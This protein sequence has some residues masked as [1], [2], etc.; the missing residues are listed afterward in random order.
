MEILAANGLGEFDE[1]FLVA[2]V[3]LVGLTTAQAADIA[4]RPVYTKAPVAVLYTWAGFYVGAN[5][6]GAVGNFHPNTS[7]VVDPVN[8]LTAANAAIVNQQ[9]ALFGIKPTGFV[10]GIQA[11]YN[12]QS[13][14][15]LSGLEADVQSFHLRGSSSIASNLVGPIP[16]LLTASAS[17]DWLAT[18]RGRLGYAT[19]NWLFY[20][21][22]GAAITQLK[23]SYTYFDAVPHN[24]AASISKT[25]V[26]YVV[27]AGVETGISD[28]WTVKA[29]YL[30]VGFGSAT[31]TGN[32][33]AGLP[34]QIINHRE[35]LKA[36]IGRVGLNYKLG[37]Y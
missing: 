13:G 15:L 5:V 31:A 28:R 1:F 36:N 22:G 3:T 20:A 26:G 25:M 34:L 29:E 37:N 17:T 35:D 30:Y 18:F 16:L 9:G 19:N 32:L 33:D 11:G 21:T 14:N 6:G 24:E 23:G 8:G 4:A 27:G 12:W 10:G 2:A 7:A